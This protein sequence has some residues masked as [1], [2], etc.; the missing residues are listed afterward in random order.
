MDDL[1]R[2]SHGSIKKF[3]LVAIMGKAQ[4][5]AARLRKVNRRGKLALAHNARSSIS[6]AFDPV[7]GLTVAHRRQEAGHFMD[8]TDVVLRDG[9]NHP[10]AG[11]RTDADPNPHKI[12]NSEPILGHVRSINP[13]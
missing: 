8:A 2:L 5:S 3:R 12:T 6:A 13:G 11:P 4:W 9:I 7:L 10:L 1:L